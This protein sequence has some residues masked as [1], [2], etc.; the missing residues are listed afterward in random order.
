MSVVIWSRERKGIST[1]G[2]RSESVSLI[3]TR[4]EVSVIVGLCAQ[5]RVGITP[6]DDELVIDDPTNPRNVVLAREVASATFAADI[7][8]HPDTGLRRTVRVVIEV[9][10]D[11]DGQ[12]LYLCGSTVPRREAFWGRT[13]LTRK[14]SSR[15]PAMASPTIS[16]TLP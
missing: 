13:L 3:G 6:F 9:R 4:G 7:E 5:G 11:V 16:S 10:L 2:T 12:S 8:P 1:S 14:T 15:R